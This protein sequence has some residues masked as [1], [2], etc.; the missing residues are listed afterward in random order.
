[1]KIKQ[2]NNILLSTL[3]WKTGE[4]NLV[5]FKFAHSKPRTSN[6]ILQ[7]ALWKLILII[8]WAIHVQNAPF[9]S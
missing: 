4:N 7:I 5:T 2:Y 9:H 3:H 8:T 1:M 6:L